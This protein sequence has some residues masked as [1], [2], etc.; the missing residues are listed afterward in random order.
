MD[1]QTQIADAVIVTLAAHGSRGLTHRA[2]DRAAGLPQGSTSY[3]LRTRLS[4]LEAAVNRL[5]DLDTRAVPDDAAGDFSTSLATAL[6][7][8][9]DD[10]RD[11]LLA[12]YEL[13]L[14]AARRP[15]LRRALLAGSQRVHDAVVLALEQHGAPDAA[16]RAGAVLAL[17]EGLLL[18]EVTGTSSSPRS[19]ADFRR[20][21]H[22]IVEDRSTSPSPE[23]RRAGSELAP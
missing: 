23:S 1:R 3:Y 8:I 16:A 4:L 5:A 10:G 7:T 21:I 12:R 20:A 18:S 11:R 6:S 22:M 19:T 13:T 9:V 14:E 15:E 17:V 2:V